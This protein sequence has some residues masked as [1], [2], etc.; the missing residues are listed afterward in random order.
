MKKSPFMLIVFG[1]NIF[2][3]FFLVYKNNHIVELSFQKQNYEKTKALLLKEK[4][5]L[6]QQLCIAQSKSSIKN[7]AK[8]ELTMEKI[9]PKNI[10]TIPI[11]S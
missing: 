7:F 11:P 4:N 1:V 3:L 9:K 6:L 2:I 10:K 5:R 8:N